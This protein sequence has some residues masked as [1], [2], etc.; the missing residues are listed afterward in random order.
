MRGPGSKLPRHNIFGRYRTLQIPP[1]E[2]LPEYIK[3]AS[4]RKS[5][6]LS[7]RVSLPVEVF[8]RNFT[9]QH[10]LTITEVVEGALRLLIELERP[11]GKEP[12]K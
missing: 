7:C 11:R 4:N 6:R 12:K 2:Q 9:V 3:S 1:P 10:G 5:A 8:L